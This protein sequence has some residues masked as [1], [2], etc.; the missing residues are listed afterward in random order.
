MGLHTSIEW[1]DSA[2]NPVMGCDGCELWMP[3]R[4]V[5][6][7][8]AGQLHKI[9]AGNPGYADEFLTP[10]LFPGRMAAAAR[11]SDLR[12]KKRFDKP[13]LDGLPRL[14]FVSDMGDA[15]S[16]AVPFEFLR[17]EVIANVRSEAGRRHV[18]L[19]LTKQ[20]HRMAEFAAWLAGQGIAWPPNLWAGTSITEQRYAGRVRDVVRVPA[21]VRFLSLEPLATAVDVAP[22]LA[23]STPTCGVYMGD[24]DGT[25]PQ[26]TCLRR[27]GHSGLHDNV[28]A[29]EILW[30]IVGGESGPGARPFDPAWARSVVAQCRTAAIPVFVKQLGSQPLHPDSR[31]AALGWPQEILSLR[32]R[33]GGDMTEWPLDLRVREFPRLLDGREWS[34]RPAPAPPEEPK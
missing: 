24:N 14:I 1:C 22:A 15:L 32:D 10:K 27:R 7:C 8:Y 3:D 20:P 19:W 4:G 33:K 25:T 23:T 9:R 30:V 2:I 17:G 12:G 28:C 26:L 31:P 16:R 6:H 18:W 5:E 34:E 29:S 11:W 13:W 21:G